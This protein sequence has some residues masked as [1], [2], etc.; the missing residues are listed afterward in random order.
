MIVDRLENC[1]LYAGNDFLQ[2]AFTFLKSLKEFPAEGKIV[3]NKDKVFA[4]IS[5]YDTKPES[6]C[7]IEAHQ[8]YIDIQI[9]FSGKEI[10]GWNP[11]TDLEATMPYNNECDAGFY[12]PPQHMAGKVLLTPGIFMLLYPEDAHMPQIAVDG[13]P[14]SVEKIVMKIAVV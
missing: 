6:E 5:K 4:N 13:I 9:L 14:E 2:E 7:K 10:I 11:V 12:T 3:I 8:R 1:N